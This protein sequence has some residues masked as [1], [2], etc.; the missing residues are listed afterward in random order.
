MINL[1]SVK[2]LLMPVC[3]TRAAF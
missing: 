2:I 3:A 1:L